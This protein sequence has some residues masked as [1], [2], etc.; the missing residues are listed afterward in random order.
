[1]IKF[2]NFM[3]TIRYDKKLI[4]VN[5]M[6]KKKSIHTT[7]SHHANELLEKYK[8]F[9]D[10]NDKL[11]FPTKSQIIEKAL[12][13]LDMHFY[14]EKDDMGSIWNR[15]R[16]ELNM[17]I[18]G[19][20][21]FLSYISGDYKKAFTE[22]VAVEIVEWYKGKLITDMN[23]FELISSIKKIW[24]AANYFYNIE[25]ERG[26]WGSYQMSFYHDFHSKRYSE[27]WGLY[28]QS[29]ITHHK[30]SEIEIFIRPES[31]VLRITPE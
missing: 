23:L 26:S 27:F 16:D 15:A 20:T 17:I 21:T 8:K 13:L 4:L 12:E 1:M 10:K 6:P 29:F 30:K 2:L 24:L 3:N 11:L 7:L 25:I 18:V 5:S 14:P 31:F 28:F 19:K 22:N 9:R